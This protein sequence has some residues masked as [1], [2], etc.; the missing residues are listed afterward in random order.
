MNDLLHSLL[1]QC[2]VSQNGISVSSSKDLYNYRAYL[3]TILTYGHDASHSHHTNAFWYPD[4]G[5]FSAHNPPSEA[6]NRGYHARWKLTNN[7]AEI[8]MYGRVHGDLFNVPRLFLPCVQLRIKF[9]KSKSDFYDMSAKADTEA[10]FRFLDAT[11]H[12]RHVKPSPT[13]QLEHTIALEN[14]NARYDIP[15]VALKTFTFGA[16]SKYVSIDNAVLRTLPKR[17]LSTMLRNVDLTGSPDSNPYFFRHFGLNNLSNIRIELKFDEALAEAITN[18]LYQEF[19][20]SIQ[21]DRLRNI[22]T[23]FREARTHSRS[24]PPSATCPHSRGFSRPIFYVLIHWQE[25]SNIQLS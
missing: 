1:S 14:V 16:G 19:D 5:D 12:V 4:E 3:E 6:T 18:L 24:T 8:E 10:I 17:L 15:R 9:T 11:L 23:D 20:A 22:L 7:G 21:I 25:S 2:N 13:I